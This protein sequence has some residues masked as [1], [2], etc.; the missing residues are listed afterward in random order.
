[1][2]EPRVIVVTGGASGIGRGTAERFASDGDT[3]VIA[4]ANRDLGESVVRTL[5]AA[6]ARVEFRTLDVREESSVEGT[7]ADI[8]STVG[9]IDVLVNSAGVL[10]NPMSISEMSM[11]EHDR[12]WSINNRGLYMC[13]RA[14]VGGMKRRGAGCIVN[15]ASTTSFISW[16]LTAYVPGKAAVKMLTE[17]L[18]AELG[19]SGVR[20]NAVA[21]H[22]TVTPAIQSRIDA[23]ER[24]PEK[25]VAQNALPRMV[26]IIDVAEAIHFL[27]SPEAKAIT[28][29][30]LPVDCGYLVAATYKTYP[31]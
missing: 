13:C 18:A 22:I 7:F 10:Q 25:I 8:A 29:V 15:L 1:M 5:G 30:T 9:P 23:G 21:P 19:P 4:D 16:P 6:G 3:I 14:V 24:D 12:M 26:E 11:D 28:G 27:C 20:V 17:V 2:A 31:K